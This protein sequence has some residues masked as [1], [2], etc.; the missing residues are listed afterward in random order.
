MADNIIVSPVV[1]QVTVSPVV[2]SLTVTASGPQGAQGIQGVQGIKGDTGNT[3][4]PGSAATIAVGSTTTGSPGSSASVTNSGSSSAAVFNFT[5]PQGAT[6][7]TGATGSSGVIAVTSPIT[8][9]GTSTSATLG[10]DQSLL[11]VA[12]SQVTGLVSALAGKAV[13]TS[14]Q[15]FTGT[16]TLIPSAA[17]SKVLI[18]KGAASQSAN[19][20]EWQDSTGAVVS[21]ATVGG[22]WLGAG[23]VMAGTTSPLA[24]QFGVIPSSPTVVGAIVKGATSQTANLQEWQNSAGT[25]IAKVDANGFGTFGSN[26][27]IANALI[28]ATPYGTTQVGLGIRPATSGT[29]DAI[30]IQNSSATTLG[31]RNALA[32]IY[33][34][35]TT[36]ILTQV[37]GATTAASGTGTTATITL[38]SASNAAVGDLIT[39]AGVTPT[40]YNGTFVVTAVSNTSPFTVSYANVTT[41]SQ[42]VAGTVSLPA[43]AS[44]T[45]RSAGTPGLIVKAAA[46][47][48]AR[49]QSW[50]DSANIEKAYVT[51]D[52]SILTGATLTANGN[53]RVGGAAS[54]GGGGGVIGIVNS[55]TVPTTNPTGG[56][57]L[58]AE[59]GALK[60]RGSSGTVTVIAAA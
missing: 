14:D 18:V 3:G 30:T 9:S 40:G 10:I 12:Q 59:G 51:S 42:T 1:N 8:N 57:V 53:L 29:A 6:G 38:T 23:V 56:G 32:Q 33:T 55:P 19:L 43:Q 52:G 20:Q 60:W 46:S 58:Y 31:G 4:T 28:S 25:V 54:L 15:T 24:S 44:V 26:T 34:G 5:I 50:V 35:S 16:Q 27:V 37:G 39:V 2:Y 11:T 22:S 17:A 41:G 36:P 49:I 45:A 21:R 47:Q 48:V 7:S 13:L